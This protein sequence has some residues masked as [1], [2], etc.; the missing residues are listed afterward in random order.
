[1]DYVLNKMGAT[2]EGINHSFSNQLILDGSKKLGYPHKEVPQNIGKHDNHDCGLCHLG[3]KFGIKQ[4]SLEC[5][6][7][8]ALENGTQFMTGVRVDK[9][10]KNA[11]GIATGVS[12]QDVTTGINFTITGPKKFV[13][14]GGSLQTPVILQNSGFRNKNIGANL[15]LHPVVCCFGDFGKDVVTKPY[16]K[17]ILTSV[18]TEVDDLDGKAHGPKI[19]TILHIPLIESCLLPWDS[20]NQIR[21]DLLKYNNLAALLVITRDLGSGN[22]TGDVNKPGALSIDYVVNRYD[23]DALREGVICAANLLYIE[24]AKEIIHPQVNFPKF[25]SSKPKEGRSID[26]KEFVKW[27]EEVAKTPLYIYS[28]SFGSAHQMSSCRISGKGPKS[29]ACDIKGR[30]YECDN[31]YVADSSALPTASGVNPM[32]SVMAL[33]RLVSLGIANDLRQKAKF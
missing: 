10:L 31:I 1:M 8:D 22:V 20:S 26:D 27:K 21:Q 30:L 9:I 4:G 13:V 14:C 7:R 23:R 6:F 5:W 11:A 19:E 15:K 16:E 12:C 2:T 32:V 29:G 25:I 18:C 33:A 17:P 24:G 3:C 28:T